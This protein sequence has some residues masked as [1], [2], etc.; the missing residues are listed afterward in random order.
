M[1]LARINLLL[2]AANVAAFVFWC[3]ELRVIHA[4]SV[5][6]LLVGAA[7]TAYTFMRAQRMTFL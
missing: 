7:P 4:Q 1:T 2:F 3:C 6:W 5:F